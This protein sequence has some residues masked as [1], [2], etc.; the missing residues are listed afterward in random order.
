MLREFIVTI[1]TWGGRNTIK[2]SVQANDPN[3][4]KQRAKDAV[5]KRTKAPYGMIEVVKVEIAK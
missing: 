2:E 5:H 4:A 1:E 3:K